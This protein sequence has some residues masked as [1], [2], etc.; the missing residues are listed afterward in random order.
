[1]DNDE[2]QKQKEE[3]ERVEKELKERA[4]ENKK[5]IRKL[6]ADG[7][8]PE[9][10]ALTRKERKHVDAKELNLLRIKSDDKRDLAAVNEELRDYILEEAYKGFDFD[11]LPNNVVNW[12]AD[13]VF[14][15]TFREP[16]VHCPPHLVLTPGLV[17]C[18]ELYTA[19]KSKSK[20][21]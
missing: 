13:Y 3:M 12:F 1:M 15:I 6:V 2:L 11:D 18:P 17:L 10:R 5:V 14:A 16:R 20:N 8:L 21:I 19:R 7:K 4:E 9:P